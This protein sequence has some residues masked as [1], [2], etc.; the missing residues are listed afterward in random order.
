M[1]DWDIL[2]KNPGL[3]VDAQAQAQQYA[4]YIEVPTGLDSIVPFSQGYG[5]SRTLALRVDRPPAEQSP[6]RG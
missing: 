5:Q 2:E 3:W 6:A 4:G 1:Y